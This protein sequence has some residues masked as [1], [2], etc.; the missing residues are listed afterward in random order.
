M[1]RIVNP[2]ISTYLS[3][4]ITIDPVPGFL[5]SDDVDYVPGFED[6]VFLINTTKW[7]KNL[8]ENPTLRQRNI[9]LLAENFDG[10]SIFIP[11]Y[12]P[13]NGQKPPEIVFDEVNNPIDEFSIEKA[14][15]FVSLISFVEDCQSFDN[16]EMPDCWC[17]DEQFLTLGF[18]DYEEHAILLCNYFNY[19]D[20]LQ[21]RDC[22]SYIVLGKGYP[23]GMTT[24]VIRV[25]NTTLDVEFW[26]AK[27]GECFYFDK[28]YRDNKFL[29]FRVSRS[30]TS[31][32]NSSNNICSLKEIGCIV[33]PDNVY[34]NL[35]SSGEPGSIDFDFKN[36][37]NW[38]PFLNESSKNKYFPDGIAS[39]QK[40]LKYE[41]PTSQESY[42]LSKK[43]YEYLKKEIEIS[44][45]SSEKNG[46]PL[47]TRWD[48]AASEKIEGILAEYDMFHFS[49]KQ[50][51]INV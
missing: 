51:G 50:S 36:L 25:S 38:K 27:K 15:R 28:R 47:R 20:R 18:G 32:K 13:I 21:K 46:K 42:Q 2:F 5:S 26:N 23:E 10:Y 45:Y 44:R 40:E 31:T 35:Q 6:S 43:I 33:T 12:I 3:L 41:Y 14:A 29:C 34:I 4:Y 24:Y 9:K 37:S 1:S 22:S 11:R 49:R 39:I 30:F 8:R 19:I 17:T 7:L 16:E 48:R